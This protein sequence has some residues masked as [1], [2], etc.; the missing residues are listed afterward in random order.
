MAAAAIFAYAR[1]PTTMKAFQESMGIQ[2]WF[3][4]AKRQACFNNKL[5]LHL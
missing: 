3:A 4:G 1:N 5:A 2:L